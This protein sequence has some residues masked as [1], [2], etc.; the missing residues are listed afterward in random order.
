MV[1]LAE[2]GANEEV[3]AADARLSS[4]PKRLIGLAAEKLTM[5]RIEHSRPAM[6]NIFS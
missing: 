3:L 6:W 5:A 1:G 4:G 2:S